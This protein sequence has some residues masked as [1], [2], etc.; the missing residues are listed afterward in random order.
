M[1][2][3]LRSVSEIS[4]EKRGHFV[5][6]FV[7]GGA[8]FI[9]SNF[10]HLALEDPKNKVVNY[11]KL[12]YAGN[13]NNLKGIN[14]NQ[15]EF[16]H[17]DI[18]DHKTLNE[19]LIK[20]RPD[21]IINFSAE[22]HVDLSLVSATE[23]LDTNVIGTEAV[24]RCARDLDIRLVHISTDEVYGSLEDPI[25]ATE[26]TKFDPNSPYSV[27]KAAGDML[28]KAHFVSF[29]TEV[30]VMRGSNAYGPRQHP[31]KLIP[32]SITN[33]LTNR[34]IGIYGNGTNIR[35]WIFV[36]DFCKG[37]LTAAEKGVAGDC[38]NLGGGHQN[39][40]NNNFIAETLCDKL[41]KSAKACIDYVVDRKGHD[42]RYALNSNKLRNELGWSPQYDL[43]AGLEKTVSWY[44]DNEWWWKNTI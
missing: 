27:S 25:E 19:S 5:K 2:S 15:Y 38:Y 8:G 17:A 10:I 40:I 23:F 36:E 30:I 21:V 7:T 35:E 44:K 3:P 18:V 22:S 4:K 31:E 43:A 42:R 41:K 20:E 37:V 39:R 16:I 26:S 12:T 34:A 9:G 11:D 33:L 13:L 14:E 1:A 24:L 32:K 29:G 6:Y 28:C